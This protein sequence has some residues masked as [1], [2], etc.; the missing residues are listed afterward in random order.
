MGKLV[1]DNIPDRI[2]Q[3]GQVPV[4]RQ[5]G[6]EEFLRTLLEKLQEEAREV[7]TAASPL[8]QLKELADVLE[9]VQAILTMLSFS[10]Q[11]LEAQ[12]QM[13]VQTNGAFEQRW[14]LESVMEEVDR[15]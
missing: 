15:E 12:R 5:L 1:R 11:D 3:Q 4:V 14:F 10:P 6:P 7:Q 13:K 9:V 2:R 8:E